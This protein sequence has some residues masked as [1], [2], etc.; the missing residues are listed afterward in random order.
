[1][2]YLIFFF[3]KLRSL[4]VSLIIGLI[5]QQPI[6]R[7]TFHGRIVP[8]ESYNECLLFRSLSGKCAALL[9]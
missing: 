5:S 6:K 1:M 8:T 9:M 3:Y 7:H 2:I 4:T